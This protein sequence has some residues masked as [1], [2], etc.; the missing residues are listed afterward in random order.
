[1]LEESHHGH[2]YEL[3]EKVGK[4]VGGNGDARVSPM[5]EIELP[6]RA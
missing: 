4:P 1:M 5:K 3:L 2:S 6:L